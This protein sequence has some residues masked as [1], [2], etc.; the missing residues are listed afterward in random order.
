MKRDLGT[1]R[2]RR[3]GARSRG[4]TLIEVVV[5][6]AMI[7]GI[8]AVIYTVLYST[9]DTKRR[10]ELHVARSYIGPLLLDQVE[11]DIRQMFA[12]NINHGR[13]LEGE[14]KRISGQ[15]A[16]ELRLVAMTPSTSARVDRDKAVFSA[17]NEVGYTLTE[18]PDNRDF[19]ILWRRE[20][21]FVDDDPLRGGKG[22][23]LYRRVTGFDV[24]YFA[25][26]G[27]EAREEDSWDME[28]RDDKFPAAIQ[29]ELTI[30]VEPRG[31]GE[32]LSA[33]EL[34]RTRVTFKR[35]IPLPQDIAKQVAIL[36]S[37]PL[38]ELPGDNPAEG[39][40]GKDKGGEDDDEGGGFNQGGGGSTSTKGSGGG[41]VG[42][43]GG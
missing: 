32:R 4:F 21:F 11:H 36:P 16:D 29:V 7:G 26:L 18:N 40:G 30:E 13:I 10:A 12:F 19:L 41:G 2:A 27:E 8:M 35:Y 15:E 39:R 38:A 1:M 6:L 37:V 23:P 17:V 31:S 3:A 24:K 42:G 34:D 5:T 28:A 20:D 9:L 25:E 33:E 14:D 43:F 22:T